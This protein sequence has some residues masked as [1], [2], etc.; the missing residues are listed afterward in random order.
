MIKLTVQTRIEKPI[1]EQLY[2]QIV[3]EI[4]SGQL[5]AN[6]CLPSIR[7]VA[8]E[9]QISVI[10]VKTAYEMLEQDGY[11]YTQQGKGCFVKDLGDELR[12]NR[13]S[14]VTEKIVE[15]KNTA[16]KLGLSGD[17]VTTLIEKYL[18]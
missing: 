16:D 13:H 11:I 3:S 1:Y 2:S 10:P 5:T 12:L 18:G 6:E 4:L 14:L 17:E 7:L 15:L 9:L 8:K